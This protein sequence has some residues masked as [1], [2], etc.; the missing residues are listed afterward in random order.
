MSA[1]QSYQSSADTDQLLNALLQY[2]Q[3][4]LSTLKDQLTQAKTFGVPEAQAGLTAAQQQS[5]LLQ[6]QI[7][8]LKQQLASSSNP[9]SFGNIVST[10]GI[11]AGV[12]A[13]M[14]TGAGAIV[15]IAAG[16]AA[17]ETD[18]ADGQSQY[19]AAGGDTADP[20]SIGGG[21]DTLLNKGKSLINLGK[22]L[23]QVSGGD[24]TGGQLSQLGELT[25]ESM[26]A[27]LREQQEQEQLDSANLLVTQL[28][29][30]VNDAQNLEANWATAVNDLNALTGQLLH[31][32]QLLSD[33]VTNDVF[34]S[35]RALEVYQVQPISVRF[36]YG[37]ISP[38]LDQ[39]PY[40]NPAVRAGKYG[41]V[42]A[43]L[44]SYVATAEDIYNQLNTGEIT[45]FDVV[46]P[47][48]P[49]FI[50]DTASIEQF[51]TSRSLQFSLTDATG[52]PPDVFEMKVVGISLELLG[53]ASEDPVNV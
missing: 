43:F 33:R 15:A 22:T 3:L 17:V 19:L 25:K 50:T 4:T 37:H 11:V 34:Q 35:F 30:E 36:D 44:P 28:T 29:N 18:A 2:L 21:L 41:A 24:T 7:A 31:S 45:G 10:I 20:S 23:S 26:I 38:D 1:Y 32:Y 51:T 52:L 47:L 27:N 6:S 8:T 5:S 14:S 42:L 40:S 48:V 53:A 13:G 16:I 46:H 39:S 9:F 12:V 49:V